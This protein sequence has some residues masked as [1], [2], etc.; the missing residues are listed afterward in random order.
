MPRP[1][2][3]P[4]SRSQWDVIEDG[5]YTYCGE[6]IATVKTRVNIFTGEV[7]EG[8]DDEKENRTPISYPP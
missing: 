5:I 7:E 3:Y 8:I 4:Y 2:K 1:K 6:K